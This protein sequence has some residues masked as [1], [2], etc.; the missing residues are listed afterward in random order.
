MKASS[1]QTKIPA[2]SRG[3]IQYG[4]RTES[5]RKYD[6]AGAEKISRQPLRSDQSSQVKSSSMNPSEKLS[7]KRKSQARTSAAHQPAIGAEI[8]LSM[9]IGRIL[10]SVP[11]FC[12][13]D[14]SQYV[15]GRLLKEIFQELNERHFGGVLPLPTLKWNSRLSSTAGRFCPGSRNPLFPRAPEIDVASYLRGIPDGDMHIRD[16]V[17]HEMIHYYLWHCR[18]PYGHTAE[19]HEILRR[20]GAK[21]FNPVPKQKPVKYWYECPS[22]SVRIPARRRMEKYACAKC[23][24]RSNGGYFSERF[25]LR[26]STSPA[27]EKT[28]APA[29]KKENASLP[30]SEVMRRLEELKR[31]V[32]RARG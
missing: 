6:A 12:S 14:H 24:D 3:K 25:R 8:A 15:G 19:F 10:N 30:V 7:P 32:I 22:C 2:G 20:V 17:L 18:R 5:G 16:T 13:R 28:S 11:L 21:R 4:S 9:R 27:P 23:C 26:L 31:I 1:F 29:P